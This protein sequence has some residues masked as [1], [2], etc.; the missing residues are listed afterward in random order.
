MLNQIHLF[1]FYLSSCQTAVEVPQYMGVNL[2]VEGAPIR[3]S[4]PTFRQTVISNPPFTSQSPSEQSSSVEVETTMKSSGQESSEV[5]AFCCS[6]KENRA[7]GE[8]KKQL[9]SASPEKECKGRTEV[10]NTSFVRR[11]YR[12]VVSE[13]SLAVQTETLGIGGA[14]L[15]PW[16]LS[17]SS[18]PSHRMPLCKC[19]PNPSHGS[20]ISRSLLPHTAFERQ[21]RT[22]TQMFPPLSGPLPT[23]EVF[24]LQP[25]I[26]AGTTTFCNPYMSSH[27][28]LH[29]NQLLLCSRRQSM[30]KYKRG[31]E[32]SINSKDGKCQHKR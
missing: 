11:A 27:A 12:S 3:R 8:K 9:R 30:A 5:S 6:G 15:I 14:A 10:Q 26:V 2:L 22:S 4:R 7:V 29:R 19:Q 16:S 31:A 24:S 28:S 21:H 1:V 13:Q 18:S 25:N 20:H 17:F 32:R 23:L